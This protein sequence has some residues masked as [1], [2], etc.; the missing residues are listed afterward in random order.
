MTSLPNSCILLIITVL[1]P[2]KLSF[3]EFRNFAF[4]NY[5]F[6]FLYFSSEARHRL[7]GPV[8][9]YINKYTVLI[10]YE[11]VECTNCFVGRGVWRHTNKKLLSPIITVRKKFAITNLTY[12]ERSSSVVINRFFRSLSKTGHTVPNLS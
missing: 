3:D 7:V 12:S 4:K 5:N 10:V 1:L 8:N 11:R 2:Y 6:R 9:E